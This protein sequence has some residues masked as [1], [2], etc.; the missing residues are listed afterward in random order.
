MPPSRSRHAISPAVRP[1]CSP[2]SI[3]PLSSAWCFA[4][5]VIMAQ[6]AGHS[7]LQRSFPE[8]DHAFQ[9]L[10][11]DGSHVAFDIRILVERPQRQAHSRNP[12]RLS[13]TRNASENFVSPSIW[14]RHSASHSQQAILL[15]QLGTAGSP[16]P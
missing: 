7:G 13:V 4:L 5:F 10:L 1:T 2:G 15:R 8:K 12:N 16:T 14:D 11:L 6:E 9:A 3:S